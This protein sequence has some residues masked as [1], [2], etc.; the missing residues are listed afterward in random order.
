MTMLRLILAML[1]VLASPATAQTAAPANVTPKIVVQAAPTLGIDV[2]A[3]SADSQFVVTASGLS[4]DLWVWD[5]ARQVIVDRLRLPADPDSP[6]ELLRLRAMRLE[7]DGRTL[8]IEGEIIDSKSA[9]GRRGRAYTVDII[10]RRIQL[11]PPPKLAPLAAGETFQRRLKQW[12]EALDALYFDGTTL[13]KAAANALLPALPASPD[14]RWQMVRSAPG[15]ALRDRDGSLRPFTMKQKVPSV[16]NAALSPDGRTLGIVHGFGPQNT[17]IVDIYDVL[18]GRLQ[19]QLQLPGILHRLQW[20]TQSR[21][22]LHSEIDLADPRTNASGGEP[23]AMLIVDAGSGQ[24]LE[25]LPPRCFVRLLRDGSLIG[26]GLANCRRRVGNDRALVRLVNGRWMRLPSTALANGMLVRDLA[27]SPLGDRFAL[28]LR[29]PDNG[30]QIGVIDIASGRFTGFSLDKSAD[31][32][33]LGFSGDGRRVWIAGQSGVADWLPDAPAQTEKDGKPVIRDFEVPMAFPSTF[34][35]DGRQFLASGWMEERIVRVDIA[36]G[37][38]LPPL[39]FAGATAL[40]FMPG[41]PLIWAVSTSAGL[42]M[43]DSR[44]GA[45]VLTTN[46]LDG[47][48]F[49]TVASDGRYDT[50]LGP[51]SAAFR[52]FMLDAPFQS[53]APQT[54]MRDYYEPKLVT[55]LMDCTAASSCA[56]VLKPVPPVA[57]LNRLLPDVRIIDVQPADT[58]GQVVVRVEARETRDAQ[59]GRRSGLFN[60]KLLLD[61]RQIDQQPPHFQQQPSPTLAQWRELNQMEGVNAAGVWTSEFQVSVPTHHDGKPMEFAAYAFNSDRVKSDTARRSWD[62]PATSAPKR[63][64][65][66]WVLTI[67]VDD[68]VEPRLKLNFA[69]ADA[70]VI[71]ERLA[72]IPGYEMRHISLTSAPAADGRPARQV[73]RADVLGVLSFLA[74]FPP[75]MNQMIRLEDVHKVRNLAETSPDDIVIISFSGHGFATASGQFALLPSNARWP[76]TAAAPETRSVI[77]AEDL[78][79]QLGFMKAAEIAFIIDACH[80]GAAVNTPDFKPGPMG[81]ASL[82]QL[83]FDKGLRILAATQADDVAL[84]N[85]ALK[86]GFLTAALGEG[87]TDTGGPAD[88]NSD[89]RIV[90]DEWLRYAVARLPSLHEDLAR[91]GGTMA[92]RG[93]RLVMRT[94]TAPPKVQ[95][96]SLFDF[97]SAPS[98]VVLRGR[99]TQ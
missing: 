77:T 30:H 87:L 96:P 95:E 56:R 44:S 35:D 28:L 78:T 70:R 10:T 46:F 7:A 2:A 72:A 15:F 33:R 4:H 83:S 22:L 6:A 23:P 26:A 57:G 51:D 49:V 90:L 61:N 18:S 97:N 81:D 85:A 16:D 19:R 69:V 14:G 47:K 20:T 74:G 58:P 73:T 99:A 63:P 45:V 25:R 86:Q 8:H 88:L 60:V 80:S 39:D 41:K 54:F 12:T 17:T 36:T 3:W 93:V 94:P 40:G 32:L 53:L 42:R 29:Y 91:G 38:P 92:A 34:A 71:A 64:R 1:L 27:P 50:N 9:D 79:I 84:E 65:R 24:V 59:S 48:G 76:A 13:T 67:G 68:Y 11:L 43:W 21:F 52:W 31:I 66:A 98:P 89:G 55:K 82:G 75:E 62:P 37:K 5:V